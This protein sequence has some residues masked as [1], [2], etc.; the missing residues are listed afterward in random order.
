MAKLIFKHPVMFDH[1]MKT[2]F[3]IM[4]D[5]FTK[6]SENCAGHFYSNLV[7]GIVDKISLADPRGGPGTHVPFGPISLIPV[8]FSGKCWPAID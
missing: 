2:A 6:A 5:G 3:E 7:G 1:I 8:Q 4:Y